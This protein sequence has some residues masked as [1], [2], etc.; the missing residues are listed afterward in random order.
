MNLFYFLKK[1]NFKTDRSFI[2]HPLVRQKLKQFDLVPNEIRK[3]NKVD[4]VVSIG[5][6]NRREKEAILFERETIHPY[7][8]GE[9][10]W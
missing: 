5:L 9:G 6:T 3:W 10:W 1:N 2:M 4:N 7:Y 8:R